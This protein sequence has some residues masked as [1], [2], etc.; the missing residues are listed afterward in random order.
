[1]WSV[2]VPQDLKETSVRWTSVFAAMELPALLTRRQEMWFASECL[3]FLPFPIVANLTRYI[4]C[5]F[6]EKHLLDNTFQSTSQ[7][8]YPQAL[9]GWWL[10]WRNLKNV[11]GDT[12]CRILGVDDV[13]E[14]E[15]GFNTL[16]LH[17]LCK[18]DK[19]TTDFFFL[20]SRK[21]FLL[22]TRVNYFSTLQLHKW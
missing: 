6:T 2:C 1:M 5:S 11:L 19:T 7:I 4:S 8:L 9:N 21:L 3:L 18:C 16:P 12:P 22:V 20:S 15:A 10:I 14:T 13:S 17:E